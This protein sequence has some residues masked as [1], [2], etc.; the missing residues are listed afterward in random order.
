MRTPSAVAGAVALALSWNAASA[1][2]GGPEPRDAERPPGVASAIELAGHNAPEIVEA[3]ALAPEGDLAAVRF[4]VE[5]LPP[6]DL[7]TVD[8][9]FLLETARL[10]R[11]ARESFPWG[12]DVPEDVFLRY[13]VAPRLSQEP[14]ERWRPFL[15]GQIAPRVEKAPSMLEAALEVNRWCGERVTFKPT[16]RR[17]QGVFETLAAGYGRCEELVILHVSALRSVGIP[18]REAWTPY[19]ATMDN[20]HAWTEVWVDG[21]W[22]YTGACEP[23]DRLD[24]AWFNDAVRNAALV[25]SSTMGSAATGEETYRSGERYAVVNSTARYTDAGTLEATVTAAGG[26]PAQAVPVTVGLWNFGALRPI[27]RM[28]TDGD[29][30]ARIVLG[31]GDYFACAGGPGAHDWRVVRVRAGETVVVS[32]DLSQSRPFEGEVELRYDREGK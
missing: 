27:A 9:G 16:E 14:L 17:D 6:V 25:L 18:A 26:G 15:F 23:S 30:R 5:S 4:L 29:G 8:A 31:D 22:H 28:D 32:L 3:L 10:A 1:E 13:V 20:N 12:G 19:W 24:D 2:R 7:A 11:E 21:A